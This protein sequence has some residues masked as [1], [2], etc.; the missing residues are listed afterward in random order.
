MNNISNYILEKLKI[1]SKTKIN[2]YH[3][4]YFPKDRDELFNIVIN[5]IQESK[6]TLVDLNDIDISNIE[7]LS[8]LAEHIIDNTTKYNHEKLNLDVSFWDV[9]NV[10]YMDSVFEDLPNFNCDLSSWNV[11]NVEKMSNLFY[12][13]YKFE[14]KGLEKWNTSNV[15]DM[16]GT[17]KSCHN[18]TGKSIE[19]WDVS[20]VE[21]I[22]SIFRNCFDLNCDLSKWDISN[23]KWMNFTFYRCHIFEGKGL[24]KWTP[25]NVESMKSTFSVCKAFKEDINDWD[26]YFTK[27]I[28]FR[29]TFGD[30][31]QKNIPR[32]AQK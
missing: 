27:D 25:K 18:F 13:C 15:W 12:G 1:N 30:F 20:Q 5:K 14:G 17:F 21:D 24:S 7:N 10:K 28:E 11:S 29:T 23:V 4:N 31:T 16:R 19:N 26:K 2:K 9:S 8:C 3:Y 22:S 32:W 6:N